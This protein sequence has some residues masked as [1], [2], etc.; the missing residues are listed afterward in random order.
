MVVG[1]DCPYPQ[2]TGT[3]NLTL[4]VYIGNFLIQQK[5]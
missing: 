1:I 3:A 2:K 5:L 4:R